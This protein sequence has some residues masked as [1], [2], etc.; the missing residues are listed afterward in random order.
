MTYDTH[1]LAQ[2]PLGPIAYH[3]TGSGEPLLLHHGGESHKGQYS[4]FAPLLADGIRAISYDQ[5]D[6]L[7]SF[8]ST[9][10]YT[11]GDIADDCVRLMDALEIERAHVMGISFGGAVA[12]NIAV[13]H[14]SRVGALILGAT[15]ATFSRPTPFT[16]ELLALPVAERGDKMLG[17]LL[18]DRGRQDENLLQVLARLVSG[19]H[20]E[21]GSRRSVAIGTHDVTESLSN[22]AAPTLLVF[23][24]DDPLASLEQAHEL[25]DG[26]PDSRLVVLEGA[27]HG[28]SFEFKEELAEL[29]SEFVLAHR[30]SPVEAGGSLG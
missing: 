29:V 15:T 9:E 28:L 7:D 30:I 20:I 18:S 14:P 21:P 2:T 3:E 10:S 6:I 25:R 5:R 27:R 22:I 8:R 23:G 16:T 12:L 11:M 17:A 24:D 26:I 19:G 4:V 13:R 1:R